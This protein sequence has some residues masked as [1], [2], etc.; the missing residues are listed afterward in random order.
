MAT[1]T[2]KFFN[3]EKGFG[4]ITLDEA[5]VAPNGK[6]LES[7]TVLFKNIKAELKS[8]QAGQKVSFTIS[9]SG[10]VSDVEVIE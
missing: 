6:L 5:I 7:V 8:L 4:S 9:R 3:D 2:V 10:D 1:G